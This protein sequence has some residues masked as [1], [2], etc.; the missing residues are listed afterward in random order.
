MNKHCALMPVTSV[1]EGAISAFSQ[2]LVEPRTPETYFLEQSRHN[3]RLEAEPLIDQ[4]DRR[5]LYLDGDCAGFVTATIPSRIERIESVLRR[6]SGNYL[7]I[8]KMSRL[9][10]SD[11]IAYV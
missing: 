5:F 10:R 6:P 4:H 8:H 2:K 9:W 11:R 3:A 1:R 7:R